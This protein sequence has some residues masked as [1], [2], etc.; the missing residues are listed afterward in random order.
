[1]IE[2][3]AACGAWV[4]VNVLAIHRVISAMNRKPFACET[5]MAGWFTF[6]LCFGD[7]WLY[8]PFRMAVSMIIAIFLTS[9]IR[10]I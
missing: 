10:K 8:V 4:F 3:L 9:L 1:M 2:L 7:Y 5:C 6:L